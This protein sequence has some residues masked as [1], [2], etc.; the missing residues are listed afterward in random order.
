MFLRPLLSLVLVLSLAGCSGVQTLA[1]GFGGAVTAPL[2]DVG[3]RRERIPTVLLQ[4]Q[5]NPYD[6][7]N[8]DRCS[9]IGAEVARLD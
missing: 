7:R 2:D 3:L 5:A 1:D 6:M 9:T 4:A 8:L